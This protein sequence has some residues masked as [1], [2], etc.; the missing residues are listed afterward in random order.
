MKTTFYLLIVLTLFSSCKK[1]NPIQDDEPFDENSFSVNKNGQEMTFD[2]ISAIR[3]T[4]N[5]QTNIVITA[6][7]DASATEAISLV[8]PVDTGEFNIVN[9][10][11]GYPSALHS[12]T[13]SVESGYSH[14]GTLKITSHNQ[15]T[16]RI[17]G[18]FSFTTLPFHVDGSG[19]T[20]ANGSFDVEY[21][22]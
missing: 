9:P 10:D 22:N 16:K 19:H 12:F 18:T 21:I 5:G 20:F 15:T 14:S 17:K 11:E 2:F 4:E 7:T 1:I 13:N 6:N 8:L 3:I